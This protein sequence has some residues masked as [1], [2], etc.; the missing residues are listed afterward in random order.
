MTAKI[1]MV[2]YYLEMR[3]VDVIEEEVPRASSNAVLQS[4]TKDRASTI[5]T[6]DINAEK[7]TLTSKVS[8][9]RR[10][11]DIDI[12]F[13]LPRTELRL[14]SWLDNACKTGSPSGLF[15]ASESTWSRPHR[16]LSIKIKHNKNTRLE[17][18]E[19]MFVS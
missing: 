9:G 17:H 1:L 2:H 3:E 18:V 8:S 6:A 13:L 7:P 15:I 19:W 14:S 4:S 16:R 11:I 12:L 10:S 5:S